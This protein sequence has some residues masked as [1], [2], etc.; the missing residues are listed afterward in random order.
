MGSVIVNAALK[1]IA[2]N[3][4]LVEQLLESALQWAVGEI[5]KKAGQAA[6]K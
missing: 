4:Q 1:V 6:G 2:K 5:A 3:P